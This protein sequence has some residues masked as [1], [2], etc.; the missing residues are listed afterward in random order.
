MDTKVA[1]AT[2]QFGFVLKNNTTEE[3][4]VLWNRRLWIQFEACG[5]RRDEN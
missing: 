3:G 4:V 2:N 1:I 5:F